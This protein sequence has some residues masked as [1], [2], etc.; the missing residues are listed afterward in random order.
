M[1]LESSDMRKYHGTLNNTAVF[2]SK[3]G[4]NDCTD[5]FFFPRLQAEPS[6]AESSM[7]RRL[8]RLD[9]ADRPTSSI[10]HGTDHCGAD[11]FH[12]EEK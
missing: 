2:L 1:H 3:E 6:R 12:E 11:H 8:S 4:R 5:S 9:D 10:F 7:R